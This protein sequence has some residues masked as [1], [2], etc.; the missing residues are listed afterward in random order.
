MVSFEKGNPNSF[1]NLILVLSAKGSSES[2]SQLFKDCQICF[3]NLVE[4]LLHVVQL[5][6]QLVYGSPNSV[7]SICDFNFRKQFKFLGLMLLEV[8]FVELGK[9]WTGELSKMFVGILG[10]FGI[11]LFRFWTCGVQGIHFKLLW[12]THMCVCVSLLVRYLFIIKIRAKVGVFNQYIYCLNRMELVYYA[13]YK[14][15]LFLVF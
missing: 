8:F 1:L 3:P 10:S 12:V 9:E 11:Y 14:W 7:L 2:S 5:I 13:F 4:Y 6:L 15:K